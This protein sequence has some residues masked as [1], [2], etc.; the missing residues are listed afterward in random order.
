MEAL[1]LA[2][3]EGIDRDALNTLVLTF[4]A[5]TVVFFAYRV[6]ELLWASFYARFISPAKKYDVV[7][8]RD[9]KQYKI[10][11]C[12]MRGVKLENTGGRI[13]IIPIATWVRMEKT[14]VVQ[15]PRA[16]RS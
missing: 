1:V 11:A 16:S 15:R 8:L 3:L 9:T 4:L 10:T 12:G 7:E 5:A 13:K 14:I 6:I 2:L